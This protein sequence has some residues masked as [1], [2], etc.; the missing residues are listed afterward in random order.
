MRKQTKTKNS[1]AKRTTEETCI[2][3]CGCHTVNPII[4]IDA[5]EFE[6]ILIKRKFNL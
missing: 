2:F 4:A 3:R 5:D 6:F 1:K